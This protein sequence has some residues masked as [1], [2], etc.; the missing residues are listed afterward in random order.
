MFVLASPSWLGW[1]ACSQLPCWVKMA[2]IQFM[3]MVSPFSCFVVTSELVHFLLQKPSC[4]AFL[5]ANLFFFYCNNHMFFCLSTTTGSKLNKDLK[6][7]LS[8]RFQKSSPDHELQQTIRDNL[9][10]HA[11]PCECQTH[12]SPISSWFSC[13]VMMLHQKP[14]FIMWASRLKRTEKLELKF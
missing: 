3:A 14:P 5:T 1:G 4:V 11:V 9:Y 6:H 7:Y 2:S 10:R 12:C 8:Q 13:F